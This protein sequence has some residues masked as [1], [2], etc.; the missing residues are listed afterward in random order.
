MNRLLIQL[1]KFKNYPLD[2]KH[3]ACVSSKH[4]DVRGLVSLIEQMFAKSN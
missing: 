3:L 1:I 2:Q 4:S